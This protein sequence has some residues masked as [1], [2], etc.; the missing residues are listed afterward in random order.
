MEPKKKLVRENRERKIQNA[1]KDMLRKKEWT[2]METHGNM[3]QYGFPDLYACC[4]E[5]GQRWIEV[6]VD[7]NYDFTS[8][9]LKYFP[10]IQA[11]G[12]GIW[13]LTAAT[14]QE[15]EKLFKEPNWYMY[16]YRKL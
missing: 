8:A 1:I 4:R 2:V 16:L 14:Y 11:A 9:Q 10:L 6:K 7:G 12:I 3:Y 5:H 15:Y 13:I